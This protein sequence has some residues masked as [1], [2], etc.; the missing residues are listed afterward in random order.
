[1]N[2]MTLLS[3]LGWTSLAAFVLP[4]LAL[5]YTVFRE[6]HAKTFVLLDDRS[7]EVL[8]SISAETVQQNPADVAALHNRIRQNSGHVSIR[9]AA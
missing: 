5:A 4:A 9:A 8:G 2:E 6:A 7:G 3:V 1:M